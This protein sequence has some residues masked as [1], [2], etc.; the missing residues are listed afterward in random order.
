MISE[1]DIYKH[2]YFKYKQKYLELQN[3]T[4]GTSIFGKGMNISSA[5]ALRGFSE[6]T[7]T[8]LLFYNSALNPELAVKVQQYVEFLTKEYYK[9]V[10]DNIEDRQNNSDINTATRVIIP[11]SRLY[12]NPSIYKVDFSPI[13]IL[14]L[15]QYDNSIITTPNHPSIKIINPKTNETNEKSLKKSSVSNFDTFKSKVSK[16]SA[17]NTYHFNRLVKNF[18]LK[19]DKINYLGQLYLD[20]FNDLIK[21]NI[22]SDDYLPIIT[23]SSSS[24][25]KTR[26]ITS[27]FPPFQLKHSDT[28]I[29]YNSVSSTNTIPIC[30]TLILIKNFKMTKENVT[31]TIHGYVFSYPPPQQS[32]SDTINQNTNAS[33]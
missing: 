21:N 7:N 20:K 1:Q 28:M 33:V 8:A 9:M 3:N 19:N 11:I 31:F 18:K 29:N 16:L 6:D 32:E 23:L 2:K 25:D 4:A 10:T 27:E 30:D 22:K 12:L 24:M 13:S 14:S 15:M 17:N 26:N 5:L